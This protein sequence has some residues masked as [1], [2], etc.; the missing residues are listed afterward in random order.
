M[1][2]LVTSGHKK[3]SSKSLAT[4]TIAALLAGVKD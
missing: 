2:P 1:R 3:A 4:I